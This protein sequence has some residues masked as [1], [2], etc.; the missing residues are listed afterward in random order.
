RFIQSR[1]LPA[2][3]L[4]P[5]LA[6]I[7][8]FANWRSPMSD[9]HSQHRPWYETVVIPAMLRHARTV[10]G[11]AMRAALTDAGFDD[12]PQ[13]GLYVIGGLGLG[14]GGVP[15]SQLSGELG[16]SKQSAS[17]LIDALEARGYLERSADAQAADGA[18]LTARGLTA[19][20]AQAAAREK[21]DGELAARV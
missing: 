16:V 17:Q 15:L 12:I 6:L 7:R 1:A 9:E 20:A 10:Y 19:A 18:K 5:R 11:A 21:V 14:A 8:F 3:H 13:N 2:F 4:T